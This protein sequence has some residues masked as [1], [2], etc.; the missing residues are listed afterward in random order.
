M[1]RTPAFQGFPVK[2]ISNQ[3]RFDIKRRNK[4]DDFMTKLDIII[5][6]HNTPQL[7]Q[8]CIDSIPDR[9]DVQIYIVDDNS[10]SQLVDF[11]KFPGKR[12]ANVHIF[13]TKEG[14]GAGYARNVGLQ[15]TKGDWLLFA[16]SDDFFVPG[17]Y[18]IVSRYFKS[19]SEMVLFKAQS[20]DSETLESSNRNENIN[21]RIDECLAGKITTKEASIRVQSPWCRLVRRDFVE[22]NKIRFDEVMA[23][24][25]TMF[26]TKCTCLADKVDV[27]DEV[28]YVVT[29]RQGSLWDSRKKNPKNYLIRLKVQ[30]A[31]N[32]YVE[33]FGFAQLPILGY[34]LKS[35][36]IG[37]STFFKA[38]W[39]AIYKGAL[40]Q[41]LKFYI[42]KGNHRC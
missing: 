30:I 26:T 15:H 29:Y 24:N 9:E 20:V 2:K 17:F 39:I 7:L 4:K 11:E 25:D 41:G 42:W 14:R 3:G 32:K 18:E 10:D 36:S 21:C 13:L 28:L 27:C 33:N 1:K 23:C 37:I 8:R 22:R 38:L 19:D 35:S 40:F 6:H 16:D 31:R 34:V 5:P 12:R